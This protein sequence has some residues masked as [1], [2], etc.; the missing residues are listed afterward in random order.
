MI[1]QNTKTGALEALT[2]MGGSYD[3]VVVTSRQH[4]IQD[5]TLDWIDRH[6]PGIFQEVFFG[7]HWALEGVATK[8]S[9]ICR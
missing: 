2:R 8:K 6:F 9:D 1:L 4:A 3:L 5:L 7:N